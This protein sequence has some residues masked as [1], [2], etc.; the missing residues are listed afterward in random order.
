[1]TKILYKILTN[2]DSCLTMEQLRINIRNDLRD[3]ILKLES[4][5]KK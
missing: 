4:E 2:I 3:L 1:M 5:L